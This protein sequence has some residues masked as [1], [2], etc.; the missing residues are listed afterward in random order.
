MPLIS[1][2]PAMAHS[3]AIGQTGILSAAHELAH[4]LNIPTLVPATLLIVIFAAI[5]IS[6]IKK[7]ES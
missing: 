5:I 4:S 2:T 3:E 6:R 1:A 7:R